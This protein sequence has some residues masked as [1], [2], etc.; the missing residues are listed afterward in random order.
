[1]TKNEILPM[2]YLDDNGMFMELF[3][4]K[5]IK[6]ENYPSLRTA[7]EINCAGQIMVFPLDKKQ[8]KVLAE[9]LSR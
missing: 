6:D 3:V 2:T 5:G 8:T 7:I 4:E 9:F 1:M